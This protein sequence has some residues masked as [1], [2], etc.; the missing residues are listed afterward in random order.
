MIQ[1]EAQKKASGL[2][3]DALDSKGLRACGEMLWI[4]KASGLRPQHGG[5]SKIDARFL[6][7]KIY[8][9]FLDLAVEGAERYAKLLCC[10]FLV[11]GVALKGG[12]DRL[13]L[14][15]FEC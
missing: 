13:F 1:N 9:Q 14:G 10:K 4:R 3:Q 6:D 7:S 12:N 15:F 8:A 5:D 11:G 2:R